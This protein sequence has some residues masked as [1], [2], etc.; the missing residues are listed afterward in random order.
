MSFFKKI[1]KALSP[2]VGVSREVYPIY[3][4]CAFCKEV[5]FAQVDLKNDLSWMDEGNYIARKTLVGSNRCFRRIE[6]VLHFDAKR[7]LTGRD[8]AGGSFITAEEYEAEK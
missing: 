3:V 2:T 5:L 7:N 1:A 4:R 8:I 6:V